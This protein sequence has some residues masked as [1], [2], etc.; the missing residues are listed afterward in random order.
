MISIRFV[1][2]VRFVSFSCAVCKDLAYPCIS[3]QQERSV[4]DLAYMD[5]KNGVEKIK[6]G[7]SSNH[8]AIFDIGYSYGVEYK[9]S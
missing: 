3:C 5:G 4:Y 8:N 6:D 7:L 9:S 1:H 2:G